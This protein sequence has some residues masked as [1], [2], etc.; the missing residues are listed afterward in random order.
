MTGS[1]GCLQL[2]SDS[3]DPIDAV[4]RQLQMMRALRRLGMGM[5]WVYLI[6]SSQRI[7]GGLRRPP[8]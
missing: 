5:K 7:L 2:R 8:P 3:R 6:S 1:C 4:Y